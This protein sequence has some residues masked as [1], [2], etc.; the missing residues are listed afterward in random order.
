MACS[1]EDVDK[2]DDN[3]VGKWVEVDDVTAKDI[4]VEDDILSE[5]DND[6]VVVETS[7]DVDVDAVIDGVAKINEEL[8]AG[9]ITTKSDSSTITKI[10]LI[11]ADTLTDILCCPGA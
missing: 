3:E 10:P 6:D 8:T 9:T 5:G 4:D 7:S 1:T 11:I 2:K